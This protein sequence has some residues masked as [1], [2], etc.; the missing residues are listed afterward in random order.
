[1]P[2][3][4][5]RIERYAPQAIGFKGLGLRGWASGAST[6]VN[7]CRFTAVRAEPPS[8]NTS[9]EDVPQAYTPKLKPPKYIV[10]GAPPEAPEAGASLSKQLQTPLTL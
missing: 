8:I 3:W 7:P 1:M 2:P 10:F 4:S 9:E 5:L 6:L